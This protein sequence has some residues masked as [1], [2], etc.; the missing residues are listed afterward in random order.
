MCW[1]NRGTFS[2]D[3][4]VLNGE[5]IISPHGSYQVLHVKKF[6]SPSE[7]G[8]KSCHLRTQATILLPRFLLAHN[9]MSSARQ[10]LSLVFLCRN[11]F[12]IP[13]MKRKVFSRR[14]YQP[15]IQE[16][17]KR[18]FVER[19]KWPSKTEISH[20]TQILKTVRLLLTGIPCSLK[21]GKP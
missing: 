20:R 1:L 9:C 2:S 8:Q 13:R 17:G 19:K 18:E 7:A 14:L 16:C 10:L 11:F 3:W 5:G 15:I 4:F 21:H 12:C 6:S